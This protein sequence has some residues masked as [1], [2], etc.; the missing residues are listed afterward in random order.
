M[1]E[2]AGKTA[3]KLYTVFQSQSHFLHFFHQYPLTVTHPPTKGM[4][5]INHVLGGLENRY[6]L[7]EQK[8]FQRLLL[9][10]ADVVGEVVAAQTQPIAVERN[11]LQVATSSSVWAQNLVFERQRIL[12]KLNAALSIALVDIRFST[13]QWKPKGVTTQSVGV[14]EQERLWNQHPSR[15]NA[16]HPVPPPLPSEPTDPAQ[17]YERW[18]A[19]MRSRTAHLPLCPHCQC[20]T[21]VGELE[22]WQVCAICA[23]QEWH[24]H[25]SGS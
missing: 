25:S 4:K 20:P 17:V 21:P 11:V 24:E 18:A 14:E 23:A 7:R 8:Q 19:Q 9:A 12:E 2:R 10:W 13:A 5:S 22:R 16:P 1:A 15:L 3:L 6:K